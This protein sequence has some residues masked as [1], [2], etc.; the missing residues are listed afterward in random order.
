[1]DNSAVANARVNAQAAE[2]WSR[3]RLVEPEAR[4]Q[5]AFERWRAANPEHAAA[6]ERAEGL[7][8]DLGGIGA[9]PGGE[10]LL[11]ETS[12]LA[13][14]PARR[15]ASARRVWIPA[16]L[17]AGLAALAVTA[18]A[19]RLLPGEAYSTQTAEVR[20]L[21]LPDGSAVTLG[22]RSRIDVDF[23]DG[24]RR[25]SLM[26]G[27]AY[28]DVRKEAARPFVVQAGAATVRVLGTRFNVRRGAQ[29]TDIEVLE[30]AVEVLQGD[31][32]AQRLQ[33][34]QR[35]TLKPA[36]LPVVESIEAAAAAGDWRSGRLS[37][38]G[39]PLV[40]VVADVNRYYPPGITLAADNLAELKVTTA[41]EVGQ[42]GL[43]IESLTVALPLLAERRADGHVVLSPRP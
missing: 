37:Y 20:E 41:F 1:M 3:V 17:A 38:D 33:A 10:C 25:V 43:M 15:F 2:W 18:L 13:E 19:P 30:G 8:R 22:A 39:M 14:A 24:H 23:D 4:V 28:F 9:L 31:A 42:V 32:P 27:E 7:W 12:R 40:E 34:H 5:A 21:K 29:Q 11:Q 35:V 16:A 26:G 6:F 36:G